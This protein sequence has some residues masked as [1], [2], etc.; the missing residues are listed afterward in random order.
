[1][2][3]GDEFKEK[4]VIFTLL[5]YGRETQKASVEP[6]VQTITYFAVRAL[7]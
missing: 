7:H 3:S 4:Q 1:M 6:N 2:S 5:F